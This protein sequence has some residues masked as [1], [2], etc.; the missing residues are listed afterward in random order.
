MATVYKNIKG[1]NQENIV[2]SGTEGT[3]VAVGNT[4]Q[5]GSTQGQYRY[6]TTTGYFEGRNE[7]SRK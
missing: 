3:K 5:R 6:N 2:D 7:K 4:S 1:L